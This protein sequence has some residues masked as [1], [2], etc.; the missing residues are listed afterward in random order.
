MNVEEALKILFAEATSEE[1][2]YALE[3]IKEAYKT[4]QVDEKAL[5]II[6]E[7]S[8]DMSCIKYCTDFLDYN[9]GLYSFEDHREL[10][11]E[12]FDLVKKV[13]DKY[14]KE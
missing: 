1:R 8:V 5:K 10:T 14:E 12:E 11:K 6:V 2:T 13:V 9:I 7:K 4:I 3:Q